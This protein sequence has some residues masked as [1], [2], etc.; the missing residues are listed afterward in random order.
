MAARSWPRSQAAATCAKMHWQPPALRFDEH[1]AIRRRPI[2]RCMRYARPCPI[3]GAARPGQ[4]WHRACWRLNGARA[5]AASSL[6]SLVASRSTPTLPVEQR[7]TEPPRVPTA[8]AREYSLADSRSAF[9]NSSLR[10]MPQ[11]A[12]EVAITDRNNLFARVKFYKAAAA[13]GIKPIAGAD[14]G[15]RGRRRGAVETDNVL[16]RRCRVL[17]RQLLSRALEGLRHDGVVLR[18][19]CCR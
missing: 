14:G 10:C 4:A 7:P 9:R 3:T 5:A 15:P 12:A 1:K 2:S 19:Q 16:P 6:A 17:A 11:A 18:S 8:T 13:A